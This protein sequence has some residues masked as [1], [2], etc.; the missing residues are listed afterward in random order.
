MDGWMDGWMLFGEKC[1]SCS[2]GKWLIVQLNIVI[3]ALAS[4]APPPFI[5]HSHIRQQGA[6][7][8]IL[9]TL[10]QYVLWIWSMHLYAST[11]V[12]SAQTILCLTSMFF[13]I[14]CKTRSSLQVFNMKRQLRGIRIMFI[15]WSDSCAFS[16][17]E[18]DCFVEFELNLLYF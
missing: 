5:T 7:T 3:T 1:K 10:A 17:V 8:V 13:V 11:P 14:L 18:W 12:S 9:C 16:F 6:S 4:S 15:R 2:Q